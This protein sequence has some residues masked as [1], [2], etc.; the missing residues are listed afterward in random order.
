[1]IEQFVINPIS[2]FCAKCQQKKISLF[3]IE[4]DYPPPSCKMLLNSAVTSPGF[5]ASVRGPCVIIPGGGLMGRGRVE[6]A[7]LR[8][9]RGYEDTHWTPA[10]QT[11]ATVIF[12]GKILS[13]S[14]NLFSSPPVSSQIGGTLWSLSPCLCRYWSCKR[15]IDLIFTITEKAY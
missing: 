11:P 2:A 4:P 1:M 13:V 7:E 6:M 14:D 15:S 3:H 12:R 8:L 5:L 10:Q 9:G